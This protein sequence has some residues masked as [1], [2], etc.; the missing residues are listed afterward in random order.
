[1]HALCCSRRGIGSTDW[2]LLIREDFVVHTRVRNVAKRL[3]GKRLWGSTRTTS[4]DEGHPR[5]S[6]RSARK[7]SGTSATFA[8]T[9]ARS[10]RCRRSS[11][12]R[13]VAASTRTRVTWLCTLKP[14]DPPRCDWSLGGRGLSSKRVCWNPF[15]IV[16]DFK[17]SRNSEK[18]NTVFKY[19]TFIVVDGLFF[20]SS[21]S[22]WCIA[23]HLCL[24]TGS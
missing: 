1:M 20:R 19:V 4:T 24:I 12:A 23:R 21:K 18:F 8:V 13:T 2:E 9:W 3:R 16:V 5:S 11:R 17:P 10:T 14:V 15:R 22:Y 7:V 6:V